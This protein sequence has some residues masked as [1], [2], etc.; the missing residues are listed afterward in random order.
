MHGKAISM[1]VVSE[2][3]DVPDMPFF[4]GLGLQLV[5]S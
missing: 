3:W 4:S 2:N 1:E 5:V